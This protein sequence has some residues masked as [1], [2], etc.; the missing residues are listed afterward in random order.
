M[1][2]RTG[3]EKLIGPGKRNGTDEVQGIETEEEEV[4][5]EVRTGPRRWM[6]MRM[7]MRMRMRMRKSPRQRRLY[8][9]SLNC[10]AESVAQKVQAMNP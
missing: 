6:S 10:D 2:V 1:E 7:S 3:S 4:Q 5:V 8:S 9:E